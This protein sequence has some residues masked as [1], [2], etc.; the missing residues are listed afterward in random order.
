MR[1]T[2]VLGFSLMELLVVM[3]IIAILAA[4]LLPALSTAKSRAYDADCASN[5]RQI[6][7]ALYQY[8]TAVGGGYFPEATSYSGPQT[9][10]LNALA[11]YLGTNSPV[12]FCKRYIKAMKI[13]TTAEF[14]NSRIGYFYWAYTGAGGPNNVVDA[15]T[16]SG[17]WRESGYSTNT[18]GLVLVSDIFSATNQ[19]HGGQSFNVAL[20]EPGT[21][22]L[23]AG[24]S[25]MKIAPQP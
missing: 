10:L 3:G 5:L 6:G 14:Q 4:I 17:A 2:R 12:W 25:A 24:G 9:A 11:E 22:V 23:V 16:S 13:D 20:S 19:L 8:A 15:N 7:T 21:F 18:A 1:Q